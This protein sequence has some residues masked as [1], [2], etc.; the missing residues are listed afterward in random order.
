MPG[1]GNNEGLVFLDPVLACAPATHVMIVGVGSYLSEVV[2]DVTSPPVSARAFADWFLQDENGFCNPAKPLGSVA[3]A[4]SEAGNGPSTFAGTTVPRA[5]FE[6]VKSALQAWVRRCNSNKDNMMVLFVAA[7]GESHG[8]RTAI[9]L[10][11]FGLNDMDATAGMTEIEQ[12]IGALENAIPTSQLLLFDCCRGPTQ[13][14]LP[15]DGPF[16]TQLLSLARKGDDHGEV[17]LQWA[18]CSTALGEEAVGR[19]GKTTLFTEC[20]LAA[21]KGVAGDPASSDWPVKPG[22][23]L[24]RVAQLLRLHA[25]PEETFQSPAGRAAGTFDI[26][27]P[28]DQPAKAYISLYDR[29]TWPE[30]VISVRDGNATIASWRGAQGEPAFTVVDLEEMHPVTVSA[31]RFGRPLGSKALMPR[32]PVAFVILGAP[33]PPLTVQQLPPETISA[34]VTATHG[35]AEIEVAVRGGSPQDDS[36]VLSITKLSAQGADSLRKIVLGTDR[37]ESVS[38]EPGAYAV[39]FAFPDGSVVSGDVM[40]STRNVTTLT[41]SPLTNLSIGSTSQG[42]YLTRGRA[43]QYYAETKSMAPETDV[44]GPA[45]VRVRYGTLSFAE[46]MDPD[47]SFGDQNLSPAP[48]GFG[49]PGASRYFHLNPPPALQPTSGHGSRPTWA[50]VGLA[51]HTEIAAFPMLGFES[52][53]EL[54]DWSTELVVAPSAAPGQF[55]SRPVVSSRQWAGL[56]G[57]LASRD[58]ERAD[59]V[60]NAMMRHGNVIEAIQGKRSNPLAAIAGALVAVGVGRADEFPTLWLENLTNWFPELPDGPVILARRL[61]MQKSPDLG[62]V[63]ELLEEGYQRGVPMFSLSCDWLARGLQA[64][65]AADET[66]ISTAARLLVGSIDARQV[67]TVVR[68]RRPRRDR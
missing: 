8:R 53:G 51:D 2:A 9:L 37:P 12:L 38:V 16:G 27:Y 4:L 20:L 59:E 22:A 11:D 23:L 49:W 50:L 28:G 34:G 62:R 40:A 57:F 19:K 5:T 65:G 67:F 46:A 21:M 58:F 68:P 3:M 29:E 35:A 66:E 54:S 26:T 64:V 17:R 47:G 60:L 6:N 36:I 41:A 1:F 63:R 39:E 52:P 55:S 25:R 61:L 30:T 14:N 42:A 43:E 44:E 13:V 48:G 32:A 7:H 45:E 24:D 31:E 33:A 15:W 56:L 18:L 10:E